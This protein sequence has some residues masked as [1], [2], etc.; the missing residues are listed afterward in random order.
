MQISIL[1]LLLQDRVRAVRIEAAAVLAG[2]PTDILSAGEVTALKR[3]TDE[4][5]AAQSFNADRPE[6]HVN[7]A[8]LFANEKRFAEAR[9][10]LLVALSLDP[11]STQAVVNLADLDREIGRESDRERVLRGAIARSPNDASLQHALGLLLV[12]EGHGREALDRLAAAVR[13]D[14]AN[15]R[16]SYVYAIALTDAGR[17]GKALEVLQD[18][19]ARHPYDRDSLAALA[20]LYRSAGNPRKAVVYAKRLAELEPDDAQVQQQ[21]MQWNNEVQP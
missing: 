13:L 5:V 14:P 4:Y 16:F 7:L 2:A 20:N 15:A 9:T 21:L 6:A 19:I 1:T 10:E 8:L 11:L 12:R 18:N 3:A 17:T